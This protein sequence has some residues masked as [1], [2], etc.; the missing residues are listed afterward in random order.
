MSIP[1]AGSIDSDALIGGFSKAAWTWSGIESSAC[2]PLGFCFGSRGVALLPTVF[3]LFH[4]VT[5]GLTR[6][7]EVETK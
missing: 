6:K 5:V 4:L 3:I 1:L 2:D 7:V